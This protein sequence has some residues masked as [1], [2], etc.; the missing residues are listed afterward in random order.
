MTEGLIL[1]AVIIGIVVGIGISLRI[2]FSRVRDALLIGDFSNTID[3][4]SP[5]EIEIISESM[6]KIP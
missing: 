6:K 2:T 1:Y 3:V 5:E 4:Y